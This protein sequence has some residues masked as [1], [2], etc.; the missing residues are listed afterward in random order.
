M[1]ADAHRRQRPPGPIGR[2]S[3]RKLMQRKSTIAFLMTLPL[4]TLIL[5][6]VAY[7]S[8]FAIYLSMLDR[9]MTR[10]V[11]LDNFA[12]LVGRDRFWMVVYQ[13]CL[14][15][16]VAV[17]LKGKFHSCRHDPVYKSVN[18]LGCILALPT[19][20]V[21]NDGLLSFD[22]FGRS[23]HHTSRTAPRSLRI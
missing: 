20:L 3:L 19:P 12:F 15:A 23:R 1:Q 22:S 6:L 21:G 14:F 10:F 2:G 9:S 4:L 18:C 17:L 16:V 7:P 8:G 11:G 5:L 13:T